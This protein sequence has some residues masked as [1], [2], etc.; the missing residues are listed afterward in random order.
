M[1]EHN[2]QIQ[3]VLVLAY[4]VGMDCTC[5]CTYCLLLMAMRR[6]NNGLQRETEKRAFIFK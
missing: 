5:S 3:N 1:L 6:S 2:R 4:I